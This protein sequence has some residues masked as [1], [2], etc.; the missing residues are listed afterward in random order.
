MSALG[1]WAAF[2]VTAPAIA[3]WGAGVALVLLANR[4]LR[5]PGA[6]HFDLATGKFSLPGSYGPLALMMSMFA[7]RYAI[8][9]ALA[10]SPMLV[11]SVAFALLASLA[12]GALSGAFL[13][14]S[15][16]ILAAAQGPDSGGLRIG[17]AAA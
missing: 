5:L 7:T 11:D 17:G 9:V 1:V 14:R 6:V 10:I 15:L 12:Y 2:G 16:R 4:R 13:A 3:G 8:N